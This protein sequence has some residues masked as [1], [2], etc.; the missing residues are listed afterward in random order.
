MENL[1]YKLHDI[2]RV[3]DTPCLLLR[4]VAAV[5]QV[6]SLHLALSKLDC[7]VIVNECLLISE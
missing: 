5:G 6:V 3:V 7:E 4:V 2:D 1:V